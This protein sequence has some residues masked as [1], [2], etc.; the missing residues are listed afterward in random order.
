[1]CV[2]GIWLVSLHCWVSTIV[3]DQYR[4][5]FLKVDD[6]SVQNVMSNKQN[7]CILQG[8]VKI[9]MLI[10]V[11]KSFKVQACST[12]HTLSS[13][14]VIE[15]SP[16]QMVQWLSHRLMDW[17]VLG[18]HLDTGS[19]PI[20]LFKGPVGAR[21]LHPLLP[22]TSNRVTINYQHYVI[23]DSPIDNWSVCPWQLIE[24]ER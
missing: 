9:I 15:R 13:L 6:L 17:K 22:L 21:P 14:L 5:W 3:F 10:F 16:V 7:R 12:G 1:M 18:L 4:Q 8:N 19:N 23:A 24:I 2:N 11:I 20:Q